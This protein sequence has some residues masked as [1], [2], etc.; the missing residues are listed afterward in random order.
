MPAASACAFAVLST[1]AHRSARFITAAL[2]GCVALSELAPRPL[3]AQAPGGAAPAARPAA[4]VG[5]ASNTPPLIGATVDQFAWLAG[6]WNG[7]LVGTTAI[8]ELTFAA[9]V[10]G[11]M[12]GMMHVVDGGRIVL[13]EL[14]TLIDTPH[15]VELRFRHFSPSLDAYEKEFNQVMR[16]TAQDSMHQHFENGVAFDSTLLST[17]PRTATYTR[18]GP[19]E[20]V[21][22][23]DILNEHSHP[24]VIEVTYR[25]VR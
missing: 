16:L 19:D 18:R 6:T 17:Q 22:H 5:A 11:V 3:A 14:C 23:S 10:G 7:H 15:G 4:A 13:V 20:F 12:V 9:P 8:T 2:A 21:A 1:P 25:R 24:E